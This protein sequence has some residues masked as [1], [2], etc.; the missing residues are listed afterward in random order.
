MVKQA[1]SVASELLSSVNVIQLEMKGSDGVLS[2]IVAE[3]RGAVV[4]N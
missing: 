1:R 2:V 3:K 4:A